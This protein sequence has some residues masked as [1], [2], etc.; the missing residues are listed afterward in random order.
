[1]KA[2]ASADSANRRRQKYSVCVRSFRRYSARY[3]D[4]EGDL[5][6]LADKRLSQASKRKAAVGEVDALIALYQSRFIGW[7]VKHFCGH[8][9]RHQD[10]INQPARSYTW[11]T[12]VRQL[13][14]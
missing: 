9:Q 3:E 11:V 6:S 13:N 1:M 7:N 5:N 12:R 4:S 8:Y 2:G 10:S 14:A